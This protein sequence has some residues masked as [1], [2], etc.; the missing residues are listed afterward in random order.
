[1]ITKSTSKKKKIKKVREGKVY[2]QSSY[3]NTIVTVTDL[4]GNVLEWSSAGRAGFAGA[5]KSTPYA[6]QRVISDVIGRLQPYGLEQVKVFVKGIG[7]A[8]EAAVRSLGS[9]GLSIT[10]IRDVTPIPHNGVRA[11]KRRRV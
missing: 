10:A 4:Q 6:A 8:R 5:R 2:I 1:M 3:N 7:S 11:R 9:A